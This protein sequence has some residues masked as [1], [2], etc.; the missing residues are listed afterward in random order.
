MYGELICILMLR[1]FSEYQESMLLLLIT[2]VSK[3]NLQ[4]SRRNRFWRKTRKPNRG[5][6][7][8]GTDPNRNWDYM[9]GCKFSSHDLQCITRGSLRNDDG[10]VADN[11]SEKMNLHF[12]KESRDTLKSLFCFSLSKLSRN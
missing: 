9:W 6:R 11:V 10:D 8:I 12:K 4:S 2:F 3:S 1:S 7:C 5:S